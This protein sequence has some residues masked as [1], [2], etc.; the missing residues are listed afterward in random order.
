MEF[1]FR[2]SGLLVCSLFPKECRRPLLYACAAIPFV[3]GCSRST[4]SSRVATIEDEISPQ[5][6]RVG[7]ADVTFRLAD[8]AAK[9]ILGAHITAEAD[10][11]HAGMAPVFAEAKEIEPGRYQAHLAFQMA[12]DWV[13]LL[14]ISLPGGQNVERQIEVRGVEPN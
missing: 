3:T 12:G 9:A 4:T 6:A 10:M 2:R 8:S 13:I 11:S 1:F 7:P 5:P 14:H